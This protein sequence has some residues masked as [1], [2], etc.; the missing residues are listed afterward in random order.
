MSGLGYKMLPIDCPDNDALR[1]GKEFGNRGQCNP[2]YFTVGNLVKYLTQLRDS[3]VSTEDIIENYLFLTAGACGPCRFG[4]Y[5][6]EYR[7]ALR[8]AGFDGFRVMLFQQQGGLKQAT[9]ENSGLDFT[10]KFFLEVIKGL[11]CGDI[12]NLIAYRI[13]PYELEE[14]ATDRALEHAKEVVGNA[15]QNQELLLPAL[16][17]ARR[18]FGSV[19]VDRLR[20]R[21]TVS[22]IG[23]FWAM[24]TEGDGN[25]RM[26]EF[27]QAEGA[28]PRV[29]I[30]TDWLLF[31]LWEHTNDTRQ[32]MLL[33]KDDTAKKGLEGI[34]PWVKILRM[35]A[36][37]KAVR[38][39]FHTFAN[40]LGLHNHKLADM[41]KLA[42]VGGDDY[43]NDVR[44]GEAHMEVAK[45][46]L[47]VEEAKAN[48]TLSIK[49][50]GCM[51]SASVSDGVQSAV[52]ERYPEGIF[53][54]IET[55]GDGAV[56]V[57]SRVQMML[58]KARAQGSQGAGIAR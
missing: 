24:T 51:P 1:F 8:D 39:A 32:R 2:T 3:G 17:E 16:L 58:F 20:V 53:L 56:N 18:A 22:I 36:A 23:E 13:R 29:Q 14:S 26:P 21:P 6:T 27:L 42:S 4:M 31:M 7:K 35:R 41:F 54:P 43:N 50:F 49:P 48:M 46:I 38:V 45:F 44:G 9:G 12:L 10:P 28:E 55:T 15:L 40:V 33:R 52:M 30:V 19:K 47:N 57:Y 34:D 37:D 25:Y 11:M 5:V